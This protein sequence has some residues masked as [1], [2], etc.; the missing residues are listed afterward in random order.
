WLARLQGRG[1]RTRAASLLARARRSARAAS[2]GQSGD[3]R[4]G[5]TPTGM[6]GA[7]LTPVL[8]AGAG[9][10]ATGHHWDSIPLPR[11]TAALAVRGAGGGYADELRAGVRRGEAAPA[12]ARAAD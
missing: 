9:G 11:Q 5:P 4:R 6:E 10:T 2:K 12:E 1:A 3:D 8:R 7:A